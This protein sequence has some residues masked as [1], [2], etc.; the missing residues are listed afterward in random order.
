MV[1]M[2]MIGGLIA[3][4]LV[5]NYL[6]ITKPLRIFLI[7][8]ILSTVVWAFIR[9]IFPLSISGAGFL[10]AMLIGHLPLGISA[11]VIEDRSIEESITTNMIFFMANLLGTIYTYPVQYF[12]ELTNL[13]GL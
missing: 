3:T 7:G 1:M 11:A 8:S 13:T 10:G 12:Y 2:G 9:A 4:Y 6:S 5:A